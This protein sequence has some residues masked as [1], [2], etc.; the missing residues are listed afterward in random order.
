ML[1]QF[2]FAVCGTRWMVQ[3]FF[4]SPKLWGVTPNPSYFLYLD[5]KKVTKERSRLQ[6]ILGLLFFGLPTQ[7][8]SQAFGLLKQYCLHQAFAASLK[9]VAITQ[10][11]LRPDEIQKRFG[12]TRSGSPPW[13][14][15]CAKRKGGGGLRGLL[16]PYAPRNDQGLNQCR[17]QTTS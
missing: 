4:C 16:R 7:Y 10:N 9:T 14:A 11:S 13:R 2:W 1:N 3:R 12:G 5:I 17:E 6:I 15:C 8:N